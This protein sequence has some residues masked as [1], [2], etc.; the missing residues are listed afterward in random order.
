MDT[1][2]EQLLIETFTTNQ[3]QVVLSSSDDQTVL[4]AIDE[5]AQSRLTSELHTTIMQTPL[6]PDFVTGLLRRLWD[7]QVKYGSGDPFDILLWREDMDEEDLE[8]LTHNPAVQQALLRLVPL[9]KKREKGS[10]LLIDAYCVGDGC[11]PAEL[12]ELGLSRS[13]SKQDQLDLLIVLLRETTW[14]HHV[15]AAF[16]DMIPDPGPK[17]RLIILVDCLQY[18]T[19]GQPLD[20]AQYVEALTYL[21]DELGEGVT[22]WLNINDDDPTYPAVVRSALGARFLGIITHDLTR[23]E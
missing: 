19:H 9:S 22:L 10:A 4:E 2:L 23:E 6:F 12:R 18:V 7:N 17:P 8:N 1:R 13:L 5:V 3:P 11:T 14:P 16:E 15:Y 20:V 21:V